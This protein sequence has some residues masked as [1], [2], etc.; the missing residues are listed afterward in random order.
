M[1]NK[2]TKKR[3]IELQR[4]LNVKLVDKVPRGWYTANEIV[5]TFGRPRTTVT[6]FI[7]TLVKK[8]VIPSPKVFKIERNGLVRPYPH[9]KIDL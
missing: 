2:M 5:K 3:L 6:N 1:K 9:Y 4:M 7:N 8:G